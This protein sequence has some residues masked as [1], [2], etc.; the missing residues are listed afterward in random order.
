MSLII[1]L[2][3]AYISVVMMFVGA[4]GLIFTIAE[5]IGINDV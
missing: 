4:L 3:L 1:N 5:R 2:I